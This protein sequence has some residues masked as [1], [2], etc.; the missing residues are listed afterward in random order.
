MKAE[1]SRQMRLLD[2]QGVDTRL[3]QLAHKRAHLPVRAQLADLTAPECFYIEKKLRELEE[4]AKAAAA[5][6][7]LVR[8]QTAQSDVKRE[9]AKADGD[10]QLVRDRAARDQARLDAGTGT[11]KDLQAITHELT[12]LARRQ[13]E[14]EDIEIEVMERAERADE[15]VAAA[16]A[17]VADLDAQVAAA[18]AEHDEALGDLD[19]QIASV[20]APRVGLTDEVGAD[21]LALYEKLRASHN[22]VG[23]AALHQRRCLGCQLQL[24]AACASRRMAA[25]GVTRG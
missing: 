2:L 22:G 15:I 19:A 16:N 4:K 5:K 8:A 12:S 23:A 17:A 3:D 1:H 18:S 13:A 6:D 11:A 10:V 9:V 21:L 20:G 25:L 24:N 7:H 14:L